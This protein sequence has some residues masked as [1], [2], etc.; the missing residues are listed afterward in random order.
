MVRGVRAAEK[1]RVLA[2]AICA[3]GVLGGV[4]SGHAPSLSFE[5]AVLQGAAGA[6]AVE[7]LEACWTGVLEVWCVCGGGVGVVGR[8]H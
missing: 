1:E 8:G 2:A 5:G 7:V 6:G 3:A 4:R